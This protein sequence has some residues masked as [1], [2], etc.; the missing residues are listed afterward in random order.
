MDQ[1]GE[2]LLLKEKEER[3]L[4]TLFLAEHQI[5]K[6][7]AALKK[8]GLSLDPASK[9]VL[10]KKIPSLASLE[11]PNVAR[12]QNVSFS[13][14]DCYFAYD[15]VTSG[16]E[17]CLNLTEY[18]TRK[19]LSEKQL[20]QIALQVASALDKIHSLGMYH[21]S[22]KASNVLINL[23]EEGL[24]AYLTDT[25]LAH[26]FPPGVFLLSLLEG[27][28]K[29]MGPNANLSSFW[30]SFYALAPEHKIGKSCAASDVYAFGVMLYNQ[31]M[32]EYPQ[33]RF[34]LPSEGVKK[35][36][37]QWD[38]FFSTALHPDPAFRPKF[39]VAEIEKILANSPVVAPSFTKDPVFKLQ[40]NPGEIHRPQF[41]ADPGAIFQT[42]QAIVRYQPEMQEL[43]EI[44]SIPMKMVIIQGGSFY[45]GSNRGA[46]DE[47]PRNPIQLNPFAIDVHPVTNEQF[48]RF[49]EALGAEKDGNNNDVIRLRESR[50]KKNGGK[51][52][53]ESGYGKHPVVG[54]TWYGA[55]AYAKWVGKRLP[56]EAEWEIAAYGGVEESMYPTGVDIERSQ[57]NF[58][59][60]D[61][62]AV[63][64]Y[65]PNGYGL[66]DMAGNVYEWCS[67]WYDY[68]YYVVS[69]QEPNNPKGP[70]Q[71]VY[72]VLRGGCWKSLKDDM[73]CSY[74]HRNNPGTMNG[75]YGFR[76][77]A[78]VVSS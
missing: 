63:M 12:L 27:C 11:H 38:E 66:Y 8:L 21:L 59:S 2:Y 54:V 17:P 72:R 16:E 7:K 64:S 53:V 23:T 18:A 43:L 70:A 71:G 75:T 62:T 57:A 41:D 40:I 3:P 44:E 60:S 25:G 32:G 30:E 24:I 45:R 22:V 39:L 6:R 5:L 34:L 37:Y 49:L 76:C 19:E 35:F 65:P 15:W 74:R 73:R 33:G 46:R 47:S 14:N 13:E 55:T 36:Q 77:V 58:F 31:L 50:I 4:G 20:L 1:I 26:L 67:D 78:D 28:I 69:L 10:Q 9:E 42:E 61:T 56:T 29:K 51:L 52:H 48:S 68:N